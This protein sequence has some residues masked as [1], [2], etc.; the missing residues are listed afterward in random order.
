MKNKIDIKIK[1]SNQHN[2]TIIISTHDI[3]D[4]YIDYTNMNTS[5]FSVDDTILTIDNMTQN[6]INNDIYIYTDSINSNNVFN[7]R[8]FETRMPDL[9][10]INEMCELYPGFK[11]AFENFKTMY[12]LTIEEY[13]ITKNSKGMP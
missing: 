9:R 5:S 11:R 13:K 7:N 12:N 1:E 2:D 3:A 4:I 8:E 10:T 6:T